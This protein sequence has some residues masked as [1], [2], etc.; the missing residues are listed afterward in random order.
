MKYQA[1]GRFLFVRRLD[2]E[3][4]SEFSIEQ[5]DDDLIYFEVQSVGDDVG[6]CKPG[7]QVVLRPGNYEPVP[8]LGN[9]KDEQLY[10]AQA[11]DVAGVVTNV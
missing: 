1:L 11:D 6:V 9:A 3:E 4:K 7:D 5:S 10:I 8:L 2:L